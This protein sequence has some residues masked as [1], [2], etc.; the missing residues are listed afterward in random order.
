MLEILVACCKGGFGFLLCGY[1]NCGVSW[2]HWLA[3]VKV[4]V[5]YFVC[6]LALFGVVC[7]VLVPCGASLHTW[8]VLLVVIV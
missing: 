7:Y 2:A 1:I 4:L 3:C 8:F 5:C 6:R